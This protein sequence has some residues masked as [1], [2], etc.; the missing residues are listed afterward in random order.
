MAEFKKKESGIW[1]ITTGI[2][3]SRIWK[4][5]IGTIFNVF[6]NWLKLL[7]MY[8]QKMSAEEKEGLLIKICWLSTVGAVAWIWCVIYPLFH[9][10]I[11]LFAFPA[12]IFF[13]YWFGKRFVPVVM[14]ERFGGPLSNWCQKYLND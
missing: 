9:P 1:K 10:L 6:R 5:S 3:E 2:K 4:D 13:A 11:R 12:S 7:Y 8:Y 14:V